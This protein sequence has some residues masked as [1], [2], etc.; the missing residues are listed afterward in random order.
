MGYLA[1]ALIVEQLK[2]IHMWHLLHTRVPI[3]NCLHCHY[4]FDSF[5]GSENDKYI[6]LLQSGFNYC[7]KMLNGTGPQTNIGYEQC[8][9]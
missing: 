1:G 8:L 4:L 9:T 2:I 3:Q 7:R 6:S 5:G